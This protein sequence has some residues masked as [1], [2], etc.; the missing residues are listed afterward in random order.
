V[1]GLFLY[2]EFTQASVVSD[3]YDIGLCSCV[4]RVATR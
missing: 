2:N 1:E 4:Y 3:Q